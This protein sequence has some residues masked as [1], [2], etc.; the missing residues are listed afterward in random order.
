LFAAGLTI[1]C[2]GDLTSGLMTVAG[3]AANAKDG[4]LCKPTLIVGLRRHDG[5]DQL[6]RVNV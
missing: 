6:R 1:D 2:R 3:A 4:D 5:D